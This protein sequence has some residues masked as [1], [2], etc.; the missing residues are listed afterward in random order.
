MIVIAWLDADEVY[1]RVVYNGY[2]RKHYFSFQDGTTQGGVCL[3]LQKPEVGRRPEMWMYAD[4]GLDKN[5]PAI[6]LIDKVQYIIYGD[7]EYAACAYIEVPFAGSN[8][9]V[10]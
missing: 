7:S 10:V 3:H 9:T 1:Q 5:L 2:K 6:L 4:C 8:L